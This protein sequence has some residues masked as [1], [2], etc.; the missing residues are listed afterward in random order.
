MIAVDTN[1]LVYAFRSVDVRHGEA[2]VLL[3]TLATG[4]KPWAVP[5]PCVTEFLS[6]VSSPRISPRVDA[7]SLAW[8]NMDVV[9][10]SPSVRV[11][12]PSDHTPASLRDVLSESGVTGVDVHDA[13]IAALCLESGV[14]EI[15]TSDRGFRRFKGLRVTDPFS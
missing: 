4:G 5:W 14:R 6:A 7:L 12:W 2:A 10:A 9:F 3:K 11:L 1:V 13:H 15:L 8:H